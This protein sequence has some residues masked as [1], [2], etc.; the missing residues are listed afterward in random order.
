MTAYDDRISP[1]ASTPREGTASENP[2]SGAG[3]TAPGAASG[4]SATPPASAGETPAPLLLSATQAA[5][6]LGVSRSHFYALH[7]SARVPSPVRLG[8]R[9]LWRR[10]D[11]ARWVEACCPPRHLWEVRREGGTP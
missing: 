11:L 4:A 10:D 3:V 5:R 9:V 7:D 1:P 6:T 2:L 8:S